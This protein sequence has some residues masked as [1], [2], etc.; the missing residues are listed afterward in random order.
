M[1]DAEFPVEDRP[2]DDELHDDDTNTYVADMQDARNISRR[3][4]RILLTKSISICRGRFAPTNDDDD[5]ASI[6]DDVERKFDNRLCDD[7]DDCGLDR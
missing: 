2:D 3:I 6:D 7:N 5:V 1:E 4:I